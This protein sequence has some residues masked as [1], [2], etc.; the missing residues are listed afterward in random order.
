MRNV[1]FT[2]AAAFLLTAC[3]TI[4]DHQ[5]QMITVKT[6]GAENAKC[7]L[8]NEDMKYVAYTDQEIEIM[9]SPH[10]LVV[11]CKAP[12]NREKTVLVKRELNGWVLV[13]VANGFIPGATYDYFSRGGFDYP[14]E[15]EVSFLHDPIKP[16]PLPAYMADELNTNHQYNRVEYM[17]PTSPVSEKDRYRVS[18]ELEKKEIITYDPPPSPVM[19]KPGY[20]LDAIHHEYNPT[21]PYDPKEEEK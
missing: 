2:I 11:N 18:P 20:N 10:D 5:T 8:T 19:A 16:Y 12:G 4:I 17:G 14:E 3:S 9:K 15:I 13:N 6:P 1:F 7:T 21:V